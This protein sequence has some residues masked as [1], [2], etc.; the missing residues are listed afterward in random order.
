MSK[1]SK[2]V[3]AALATV[4]ALALASVVASA[5]ARVEVSTTAILLSNRLTF[6]E[7]G[8]ISAI[9][10][11]TL[12]ATLLRLI[13]KVNGSHAGDITAVLTANCRTNI[14][15]SC[16]VRLLPPMGVSY[17]S[18]TGTLPTIRSVLL[19]IELEFLWEREAFLQYRCLYREVIAVGSRENPVRALTFL[20]A[21]ANLAP[22]WE[23]RLDMSFDCP[24]RGE[25][26]GTFTATPSVSIRL[27]ER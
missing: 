12:H 20:S 13:S 21:P 19:S 4:L 14:G 17:H 22:L 8:G 27:L 1:N 9:S 6:A 2:L 10:D 7:E 25:L 3:T 15:L 26:F 5:R 23:D 18:I 16:K 24:P 11:L